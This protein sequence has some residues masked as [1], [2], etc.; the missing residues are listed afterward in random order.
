MNN[1]CNPLNSG[2]QAISW[3]AYYISIINNYVECISYMYTYTSQAA[4]IFC[5]FTMI[6]AV[7]TNE[8]W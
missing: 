5:N 6:M 3:E 4:C 1:M 2:G 8:E 7:M